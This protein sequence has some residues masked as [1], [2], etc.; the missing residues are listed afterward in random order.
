MLLG[1]Q[2]YWDALTLIIFRITVQYSTL[3]YST[4]LYCL[5]SCQ[6]TSFFSALLSTA[7]H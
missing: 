7:L 6:R 1:M 2:L 5:A 4:L 3:L